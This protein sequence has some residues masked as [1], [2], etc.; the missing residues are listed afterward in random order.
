MLKNNG[1]YILRIED[2]DQSRYVEGAIEGMLKSM[3]WA[4]INHDEGVI[5]DKG[6][7]SQKGEFGPY[8]QS[9]RFGYLPKTY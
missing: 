5:L 7:L 8:I 2:T 3:A 1:K 6:Q 4:G 9:Q